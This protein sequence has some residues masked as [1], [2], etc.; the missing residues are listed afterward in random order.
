MTLNG[1]NGHFTLCVQYYELP[2]THYLLLIYHRLFI[3]RDLTSGGVREERSMTLNRHFALNSVLCR[4]VWSSEA[5]V[6]ACM[7]TLKLVI[8]VVDEL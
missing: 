7:A 2:L 4:Y 5:R 1:L 3:T 8:N 6:Q